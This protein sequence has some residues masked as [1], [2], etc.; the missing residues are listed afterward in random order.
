MPSHT[1][2]AVGFQGRC[3]SAIHAVN[4]G[5]AESLARLCKGTGCGIAPGS[6][7]AKA[8]QAEQRIY[9]QKKEYNRSEKNI[10]AK[11]QK[12][13]CAFDLYE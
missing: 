4:Y 5:S 13:H 12:R 8:L 10:L 1:T 3:H 6:S 2:F 11:A 7:V 9:K